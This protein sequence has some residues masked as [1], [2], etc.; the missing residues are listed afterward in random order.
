MYCENGSSIEKVIVNGEVVVEKG[1]LTR[2][3][4]S[5]LLAE[6]RALM[7]EFLTYHS[8]VET[9]NAMLSPYF[10]VIHKRCNQMDIGVQRLATDDVD[11]AWK[12]NS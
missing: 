4:E 1:I 9:Q 6:L 8:G 2:V 5:D 10:D 12:R 7:P 3:N 11:R